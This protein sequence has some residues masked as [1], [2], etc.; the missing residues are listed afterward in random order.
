MDQQ[1][2]NFGTG[3]ERLRDDPVFR[4]LMESVTDA[5]VA[6]FKRVDST[7]ESRE[8]AHHVIVALGTLAA[9]MK[10]AIDAKDMQLRAQQQT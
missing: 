7:P 2:I 10:R 8:Q 9:H 6:E 1:V 3:V 5:Q 4:E